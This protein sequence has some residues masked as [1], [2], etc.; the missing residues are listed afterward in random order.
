[1]TTKSSEDSFFYIKEIFNPELEKRVIIECLECLS[2]SNSTPD[3][4]CIDCILK[5][6]YLNRKNAI[7]SI[8]VKKANYIVNSEKLKFLMD[9]FKIRNKIK[10]EIEKLDVNVNKKCTFFEFNCEYKLKVKNFLYKVKKNDYLNPIVIYDGIKTL[11]DKNNPNENMNNLCMGCIKKY[12]DTLKHISELLQNLEIIRNFNQFKTSSQITDATTRFFSSFLFGINYQLKK[13]KVIEDKIPVDPLEEYL[14]GPNKCYKVRI[15]KL[16]NTYEMKYVISFATKRELERDYISKIINDVVFN[17]K[18]S[19]LSEVVPLEELLKHYKEEAQLY[20]ESKYQLALHDKIKIA[21]ISAIKKINLEKILPLLIDDFVEEIF[22]DSPSDNIYLNHQKFGRCRTDINFS[23]DEIERLK[24]FL[25]IYSGNRLDYTNPSIKVVVKN[26]YFNC[27]FA[28]DIDPI[29]VYKFALDIR[30]LNK[31]VLNIQDLLKNGTLNS[32]IAAFLYFL[33]LYRTNITTT[34]ETDT[35]KTTLINAL[36]LLTPKEFRKVYIENVIESLNELEYDKHQLKYQVDSLHDDMNNYPSK[37]SQIK[38][39]LHRSPDIIY[40]GEIL[41][42]E[43]AEAMFHCLSAGLKGFQTIHSN[44]VAS[45]I[46]RILFHFKIDFSCLRDLGIIIFLKKS[47]N[48]RFVFSISEINSK[49]KDLINS[50][51]TIFKFD[52]KTQQ[53]H[54]LESIF[55]LEVIMKMLEYEFFNEGELI[56]LI[57]TYTE[58]FESLKNMDKFE[59]TQLVNLFDQLAYFSYQGISEVL[60][61]WESWKNSRGLNSYVKMN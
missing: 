37:H 60:A 22:L 23:L 17:L 11:I 24:T 33:I 47:R 10:K 31:N 58:I 1:M 7:N 25:R 56:A 46:N 52:P 42:K 30:K 55:D 27:R 28:I 41:T 51:K 3:K 12:Q 19:E 18:L 32:E 4:N 49:E 34:G 29:Q 6:S 57:E 5:V 8:L 9:Y 48:R 2:K 54:K 16:L 21:F 38:N 26:E 45:L 20:L 40:L 36:D 13:N 14:I 39:L 43:E 35:G 61:F 59:N 50:I 44:T 53:W 15:Y